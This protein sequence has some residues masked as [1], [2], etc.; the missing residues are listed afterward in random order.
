MAWL[1]LSSPDMIPVAAAGVFDV[2]ERQFII[3]PFRFRSESVF[4]ARERERPC[5]PVVVNSKPG[6][7]E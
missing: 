3:R 4:A 1:S 5:A 6:R 7:S 2:V